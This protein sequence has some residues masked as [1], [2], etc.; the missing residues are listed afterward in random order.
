M[1]D[2]VK[3]LLSMAAPHKDADLD[4]LFSRLAPI[5]EIDRDE[6]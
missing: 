6:V 1:V 5:F 3:K 2:A 4:N